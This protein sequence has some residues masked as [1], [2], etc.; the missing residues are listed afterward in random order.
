MTTARE[1]RHAVLEGVSRC[2]LGT[3]QFGLPYG[4]ANRTGQPD[5]PAVTAIVAAA[6]DG[7]VTCFDTAAAYGTSEEVLGRVLHR[8]GVAER[9][10]VVTK[11]RALAADERASPVLARQAIEASVAESRRRL[12]L[13]CLPLVLFH[14]EADAVHLDALVALRDR[15]WLRAAGVSC[16]NVPGPAARLA[17]LA[18]VAALQVPASILDPRHQR[19]GSIA[20]AADRGV[21]VFV[22]SVYLQGLL[23]MPETE[24]P[25]ALA[26]VIPARR[27][28]AALAD[29][30]GMSLPEL[31]VRCMLGVPGVTSLVLGVDTLA[32]LR[33]NLALVA[34][35]PLDA[36]LVAAVAAAVPALPEAVISPPR[37]SPAQPPA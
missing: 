25:P 28:L 33:Q 14:R 7:G 24:I 27:A 16:D 13:E 30:A 11:V 2:T 9:V 8:L 21:A 23:L 34:R 29:A 18:D 26:P 37:W 4:V 19:A 12:G 35:G 3:V 15:G 17:A 20:A 22:R 36:V 1:S 6:L 10:V 31:A 32:Q 5:E